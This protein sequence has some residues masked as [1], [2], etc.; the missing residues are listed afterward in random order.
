MFDNTI[1]FFILGAFVQLKSVSKMQIVPNKLAALELESDAIFE[2]IADQLKQDPSKGK[3]VNGIFLYKI[4]KNGKQAKQ[5]SEYRKSWGQ[6]SKWYMCT[7]IFTFS[8]G[9]E[10]RCGLR[11]WTE[12][13]AQHHTHDIGW[14]FHVAGNEQIEPS[15]SVHEGQVE[16]YWKCNVGAK[17]GTVIESKF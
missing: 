10:G 3:S 16:G 11:R 8:Y 9:F 14:R 15:S 12:R 7:M 13:K 6:R 17:A 1:F 5:W 4:T 2:Y